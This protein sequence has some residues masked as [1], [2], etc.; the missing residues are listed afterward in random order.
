M[1]LVCR[2]PVADVATPIAFAP[3]FAC[4]GDAV[5]N[6]RLSFGRRGNPAD[7]YQPSGW[8]GDPRRGGLGMAASHRQTDR[9]LKAKY[10]LDQ[11]AD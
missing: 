3:R 9:E 1:R 11:L 4:C 6:R 2:L 10:D 7:A 5:G 8:P